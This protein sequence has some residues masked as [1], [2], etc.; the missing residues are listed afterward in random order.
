VDTTAGAEERVADFWQVAR[1]HAKLNNIPGYFGQN[2]LEAV[3]PPT[4]SFGSTAEE[5]DRGLRGLLDGSETRTEA[6]VSAYTDA[7]EPLPE[8]G[9]LGIVLDGRGSPRALVVTSG[10]AVA[11]DVVVEELTVLHRA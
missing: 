11:D 2:A 7:G 1:F 8:P 3:P 10:V 5:A 6:P 4:W 9:T